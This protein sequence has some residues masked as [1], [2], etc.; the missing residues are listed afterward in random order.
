MPN[1]IVS[2]SASLEVE[3]VSSA[4]P[5]PNL[6]RSIRLILP[7]NEQVRQVF[8]DAQA[9]RDLDAP[10]R[11]DRQRLFGLLHEVYPHAEIQDVAEYLA[12]E[13]EQIGDG[14]L[15]VS[16]D[17][18]K[19][20]AKV[21]EDSLYE[22]A[23]VLRESG[24]TVERGV[25]IRPDVEAFLIYWSFEQEREKGVRSQSL[26]RLNQTDLQREEGDR[27]TPILSREG[28]K[29]IAQGVQDS[30]AEAFKK[31]CNKASTLSLVDYF[32]VGGSMDEPCTPL[33]IIL[34]SR[35]QRKIQ[36]QLT[37]NPKYDPLT[38]TLSA[39]T[40]SWKRSIAS[41]LLKE[42]TSRETSWPVA[43]LDAAIDDHGMGGMW[44]CE[45]NLAR[46]LLDRGCRVFAAPG[47]PNLALHLFRQSGYLDLD[48]EKIGT[49][50]REV[51]D[52]WTIESAAEVTL[53][54]CWDFIDIV[55]ILG[56]F[57]SGVSVEV[58]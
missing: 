32:P 48:E 29:S 1:L 11:I 20:V 39:V 55:P 33:K 26:A 53:H 36:D 43:G 3:V 2:D 44:F 14:I 37:I 25:M 18:G 31:L 58:V 4:N 6:L 16:S 28:R 34:W 50:N 9:E 42:A 7:Q 12:D 35:V 24:N 19:A 54:V 10:V 5:D 52:R 38:A 30:V 46:A 47:P 41:T 8:L 23:P 15:L 40:S 21:S 51:N 57:T 17:T 56:D 49:N 27:R 22:A 13:F 45:P